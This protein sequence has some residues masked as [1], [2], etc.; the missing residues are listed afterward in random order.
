M[1]GDTSRSKG[2]NQSVRKS[3]MPEG[4][5]GPEFFG[6]SSKQASS[7]AESLASSQRRFN[8]N[9]NTQSNQINVGE[10]KVYSNN[11]DPAKVASEIPLAIKNY[12]FAAQGQFGAQ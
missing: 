7:Y 11:S 6:T 12:D 3:P 10:I 8:T 5:F 4:F 1:I 9:Q 2:E